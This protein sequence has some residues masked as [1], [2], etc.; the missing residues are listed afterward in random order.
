MLERPH[1]RPK[2]LLSVVHPDQ[3][4]LRSEDM[5][6]AQETWSTMGPT[7]R[8]ITQ[9]VANHFEIDPVSILVKRARRSNS[10][11]RQVVFACA[12][13]M[14][15]LSMP[16]MA[17]RFGGFHHTSVWHA[18]TVCRTGSLFAVKQAIL[19]TLRGQS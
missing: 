18:E 19:A 4:P 13:E 9:V 8:R 15:N 16:D 10:I 14:T 17:R 6:R 12:R 11:P 5:M 3:R 7:L 1:R 2:D